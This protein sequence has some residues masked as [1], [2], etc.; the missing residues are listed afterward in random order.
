LNQK[1]SYLED[2]QSVKFFLEM[3]KLKPLK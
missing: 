1:M 3:H 2:L